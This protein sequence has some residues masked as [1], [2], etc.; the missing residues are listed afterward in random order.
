VTIPLTKSYIKLL[1]SSF[2]AFAWTD[3]HRHTDRCC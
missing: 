2:S 1:T 3:T